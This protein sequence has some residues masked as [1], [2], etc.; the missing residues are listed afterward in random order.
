MKK[1][2][3]SDFRANMYT[4]LDELPVELYKRGKKVA[5][6]VQDV[7]EN[8]S[9]PVQDVQVKPLNSVQDVQEAIKPI[10]DDFKLCKHGVKL[11][12]CKHGCK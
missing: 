7:Q 5:S 4:Y 3:T 6:V 11:G 1:V 12:L 10:V 2:T 8:T 9:K